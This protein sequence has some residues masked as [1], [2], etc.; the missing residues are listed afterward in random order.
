[1]ISDSKANVAKS[2]LE[3]LETTSD[4]FKLAEEDLKLRGC[5]QFFG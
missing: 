5:G 4:G 3:I 2:R 1:M